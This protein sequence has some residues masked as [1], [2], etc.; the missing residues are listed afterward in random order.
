MAHDGKEKV[1]FSSV[2]VGSTQHMV[3]ELL[4]NTA[5]VQL[6]RVPYR[7]AV[8]PVGRDLARLRRALLTAD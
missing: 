3:G 5:G 8:A 1:S 2:G 7:G 6:L 4:G